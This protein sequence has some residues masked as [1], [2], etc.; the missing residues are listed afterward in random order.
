[1][2]NLTRSEVFALLSA[3][4]DRIEFLSTYI[5]ETQDELLL[6]KTMSKKLEID[7]QKKL[8]ATT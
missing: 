4:N 7:W 8:K 3:V 1:M 2:D 6:L 5:K